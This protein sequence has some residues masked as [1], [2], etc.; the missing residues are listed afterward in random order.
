[1]MAQSTQKARRS[2]IHIHSITNPIQR[3][4]QKMA[5]T[6]ATTT[7]TTGTTTA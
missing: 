3:F 4:T 6:M 1:M 5:M 2:V 7:T